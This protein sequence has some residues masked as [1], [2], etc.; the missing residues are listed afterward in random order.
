MRCEIFLTRQGVFLAPIGQVLEVLPECPALKNFSH[1][2]VPRRAAHHP[3]PNPT[4]PP[5]VAP[6]PITA[7][8][9]AVHVAKPAAPTLC[10]PATAVHAGSTPPCATAALDIQTAAQ[11]P[12]WIP[13]LEN[14]RTCAATGKDAMPSHTP[15]TPLENAVKGLVQRAVKC[16]VLGTGGAA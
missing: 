9:A 2:G 10:K 7:A 3:A 8:P 13:T 6:T 12:A 15:S 14:P 16:E 4:H 5:S 1:N 11:D